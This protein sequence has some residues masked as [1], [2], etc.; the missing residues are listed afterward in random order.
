QGCTRCRESRAGL[1]W[2]GI[3]S[4]GPA[5]PGRYGAPNWRMLAFTLVSV[6]P[7]WAVIP[8]RAQVPVDLELVL[9]VDAS[10]SVDQSRFALQKHGYAMAF[11]SPEI[12]RAIGGGA[13]QAIA[14]TMVQ[15]TGPERH[16]QV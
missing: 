2:F 8:A 13:R 16:E 10:G 3:L 9:A 12:L 1:L 7:Q 14:V 11:R 4:T 6:A 5:M 15:W